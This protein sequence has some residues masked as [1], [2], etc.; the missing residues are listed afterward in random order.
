MYTSYAIV[1]ACVLHARWAGR[2]RPGEWNWGR[3]G[4]VLNV[5]ALAYTLWAAVWFSFPTSLPVTS[6]N[7]NYCAPAFSAVVLGAVVLWYVRA[8][9]R[10]DGPNRA[11]ADMVCAVD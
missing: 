6:A 7:M 2:F 8:R 10:W 3:A 11:I 5:L 9:T 4:P 1:L